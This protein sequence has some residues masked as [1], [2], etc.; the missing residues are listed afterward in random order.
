MI[1][2]VSKSASQTLYARKIFLFPDIGNY[3]LSFHGGSDFMQMWLHHKLIHLLT[4]LNISEL[5]SSQGEYEWGVLIV[6]RHTYE[7]L[8]Y[9]NTT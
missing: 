7:V 9:L 1:G 4:E 5:K 8:P 6:F 3:R 2:K